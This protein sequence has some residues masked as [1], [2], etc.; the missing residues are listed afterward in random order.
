MLIAQAFGQSADITCTGALCRGA[1]QISSDTRRRP[2]ALGAC[3][4]YA[5]RPFIPG[6]AGLPSEY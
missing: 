6:L 3:N 1:R 4:P 2:V 5:A